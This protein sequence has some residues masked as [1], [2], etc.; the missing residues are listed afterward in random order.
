MRPDDG[1][2]RFEQGDDPQPPQQDRGR[3]PGGNR[4]SPRQPLPVTQTAQETLRTFA[5]LLRYLPQV[6][7]VPFTAIF[8]LQGTVI[9][10]GGNPFIANQP[11]AGPT[12][13]LVLLIP[14]VMAA[15][16]VFLVDWHRLV[17]FGAGTETT[18]PRLKL[19]ARD[20][21]YFLRGIMV[22]FIGVLAAMPAVML[23]PSVVSTQTGAI[24]M[25]MVGALLA[26]TGMM[27][28]GLVLPATAI[29]RNY[30]IGASFQATKDVL[31]QLVGLVALVLAPA[32]VVGV[33]ILALTASVFGQGGPHIPGVLISLVVEF[34]QM[35][36]GATLLSVI[37]QKRAGVDTRA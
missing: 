34:L 24:A 33:S 17:L 26:V 30:S 27:G 9:L 36:L 32:Y 3:G 4:P 10:S 8:L 20:F 1:D 37:F 2:E 11:T 5:Q 6:A 7:L 18:R 21:R 16:V 29:D 15:Y 13:L 25:T 28:F 22:F 23:A 35:A 19:H 12:L 14:V 31:F